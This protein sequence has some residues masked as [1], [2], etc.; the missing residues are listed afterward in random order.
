MNYF[1][2]RNITEIRNEYTTFLINIMTPFIYEGIRSVYNYALDTH[3]MFA[4][5]GKYDSTMVSPGVLKIFQTCL[6]EIPTLNNN[7]IEKECIRIKEGCKCSEWFD[8]LVRSVI[9]SNIILLSFSN[10]S[11]R[12]E[13]SKERYHE[14]IDIK[15]FIHKCYIESARIIYNS[16][17]LFWHEFPTL[18]VKRNQRE[19]YELIKLA[20]HEAVRKMLPIKLI[21]REYL[22]DN[23][24]NEGEQIGQKIP[25]ERYVNLKTLVE[26]DIRGELDE[27][28]EKYSQSSQSESHSQRRSDSQSD[29]YSDYDEHDNNELDK[30]AEEAFNEELT[31]ISRHTNRSKESLDKIDESMSKINEKIDNRE[32]INSESIMNQLASLQNKIAQ[33]YDKKGTSQQQQQQQQPIQ[34]QP[35]KKGEVPPAE[36]D[37]EIQQLLKNG[38]NYVTDLNID[39][40]QSKRNTIKV[41][42]PQQHQQQQQQ[43]QQQPPQLQPSNQQNINEQKKV[44]FD[45]YMK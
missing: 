28:I 32:T 39:N 43:Q 4:E 1:Y 13:V 34:I 16:P 15:D 21:L 41:I 14:K 19:V 6:K 10:P 2:E 22:K 33:K 3:K 38:G 30:E 23:Y 40:V 37:Q 24:V 45:Q 7:S 27:L 26:K 18:E 36:L 29:S 35:T 9:K 12:S 17:E 25:P 31:D 44:F 5:K 8:D 11:R 20:I 42:Q